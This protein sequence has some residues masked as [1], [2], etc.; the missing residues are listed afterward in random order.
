[1]I[2]E[3]NTSMKTFKPFQQYT[4]RHKNGF[5]RI[6]FIA[7]PTNDKEVMIEHINNPMRDCRST[8]T[9][10]QAQELWRYSTELGYSIEG[11]EEHN[12]KGN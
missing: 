4:L 7:H 10:D 12:K 3:T 1:M 11:E 2:N 6:L 8:H 9:L 5:S